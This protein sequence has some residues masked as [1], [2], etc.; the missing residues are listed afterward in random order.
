MLSEKIGNHF[1]QNIKPRTKF[2][3][4]LCTISDAFLRIYCMR[5]LLL[6]VILIMAA[7]SFSKSSKWIKKI[8]GYKQP[9]YYKSRVY[10]EHTIVSFYKLDAIRQSVNPDSIDMHLL[11]A[12]LFFACNK[13]RAM[14][15]LPPYKMEENLKCAASIH[16]YQMAQHHFFDHTNTFE[17]SLKTP[18]D[19]LKICGIQYSYDGENCHRV[20]ISEKEVTYIELAQQVIESLFDSPPHRSNM[21]NKGFK[22]GACGIAIEKTGND[23]YLLVTQDFYTKGTF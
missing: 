8:E 15:K 18:E 4:F 22:Y 20:Y 19:R 5:N 3:V 14:Y 11:N 12:C 6:I 21:L 16:S 17:P 9:S 10:E 7:P 23:I 1:F 2:V 13:L